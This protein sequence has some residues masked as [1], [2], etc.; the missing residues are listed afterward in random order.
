METFSGDFPGYLVN[1]KG[2]KYIVEDDTYV[3][4]PPKPTM[5]LAFEA[6]LLEKGPETM[7]AKL[8]EEKPKKRGLFRFFRK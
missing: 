1:S 2:L 5:D 6:E 7:R 4:R 8:A 3:L